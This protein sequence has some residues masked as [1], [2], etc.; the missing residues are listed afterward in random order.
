MSPKTY[1]TLI[2]MA[3]LALTGCKTYRSNIM[4]KTKDYENDAAVE[5]AMKEAEKN[6]RYKV[7]DRMTLRVETN[8][9]EALI[10]PNLQMRRELIGT[11]NINQANQNEDQVDYLIQQDGKANLPMIGFVKIEGHTIREVDSIL[12]GHYSKFY[13]KPFVKTNVSNRRVFVFLGQTAQ[14]VPLNNENMTVIEVIASAGGMNDDTKAENIRL[15]RGDLSNPYVE[16]IDLTT[17]QGMQRANLQVRAED[18][19]YVEPIR[20]VANEAIR[21]VTPLLTFATSLLA[22]AVIISTL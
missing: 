14:V 5:A 4:F 22:L 3:I 8:G 17:I 10:D 1:S 21:D 15:I 13:E 18:I 19:V 20:R 12:V 2:L 7:N 11:A 9:G 16:V 6:Y